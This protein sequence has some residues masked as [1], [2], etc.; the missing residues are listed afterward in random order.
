MNDQSA[1]Q[2]VLFLN[3]G[4]RVELIRAFRDALHRLGLRWRIIASD[5]QGSAAALYAADLAVLLPR[6]RDAAFSEALYGLCEAQRIRLIVPTI[7][8]D[9]EPLATL[10]SSLSERGVYALVSD[11]D[12]IRHCRDKVGTAALLARAGLPAIATL[13]E[14]EARQGPFPL[15]V[16]PRMG[17]S[18]V[19]SFRADTV[20]DLDYL[21]RHV[22]NPIIQPFIPGDEYTV[23]VFRTDSGRVLPAVPRLRLKVR[24]GEVSVARV[25]RDPELE[26]IAGDVA[27][28]VNLIGPG[29][30]Q[31]RR[32][33][34]GTFVLEINPRFGGGSP[35]G[36]KAGA[37]LADWSLMLALGTEP[38]AE[39][40]KI[41][42]RLVMLR[43]DSSTFLSEGDLL[44]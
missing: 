19:D 28:A 38:S 10:K 9:L 25:C 29:N 23:D 36:I 44:Q 30:V 40:V 4:R 37:L 7:D 13:D 27:S 5:V 3:A 12:A 22:P 35:L 41:E 24:A 8:P 43:Y 31:I 18:S 32:G 15:Y 34:K 33:S 39:S 2:A 1:G 21:L 16:K 20:A 6:S 14:L 42:D 11:A 26:R 17:S